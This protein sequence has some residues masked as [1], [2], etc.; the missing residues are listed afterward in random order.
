MVLFSVSEP[1]AGANLHARQLRIGMATLI[2]FGATIGLVLLARNLVI[3]AIM[4]FAAIAFVT[5]LAASIIVGI[6]IYSIGIALWPVVIML[7]GFAWGGKAAIGVSTAFVISIVA[8]TVA[9]LGGT[10]PGPSLSTL[11]GPL[12]FGTVFFLMVILVCWL[13]VSYSRIVFN[14]F[15]T[16][17]RTQRELALSQHQLLAI[18]ETEPE[19]VKVLDTDGTLQQMNRAGLDMIEADSLDQ[20][21]GKSILGVVAP[22]HREAFAALNAQVSQGRPGTLEFEVIGLKGG[23]RWLET[24]AVP[25]RDEDGCVTGLLSVTRDITARRQA[26]ADVM[27]A[28][29]LLEEAIRSLPEGFSIFDQDDRLV[30]CNEAYKNFYHGV[31][32]LIVPGVSFEELARAGAE[33]GQYLEAV[34]RVDQWVTERLAKHRQANG[35][36]LEQHLDDGRWLLIIEYRTPSGYIVGN[37][38]DITARKAAEAELSEYRTRLELL[39]Q[40]RTIA[41]T[42][43]KEAA[44]AAN[45]A[46][47]AFLANMSHEIR[48]PLN[49]ILGMAHILKRSGVTPQQ[50]ERIN[51]I[52]ASAQHLMSIIN[53]ILDIS[54]IEAGRF[55]LEEVQVDIDVLLGNVRSI[56]AERAESKGIRLVIETCPLPPGLIGDQTRLQQALL[57][58]ASNAMKFTDAGSVTL[59]CILLHETADSILV[60]FEVADTGI[61][62]A[63]ETLP[64]LFSAFEQADKSTTRKYGGTGLGLAI[65]RRL[66]ELMGGE[67]GVETAPGSGSTFWFT[68]RLRKGGA[69]P[70]ASAVTFATPEATLRQRYAGSRILV[71]DDEPINREIAHLHLQAAGLVVDQAEDGVQAIDMVQ[72]HSYAAIFMDI[73]MPNLDGLEATRQIRGIPGYSQT[74]IVA[75]TA[76]VFVEDRA[77]CVAAGMNDFLGKPFDPD[78]LFATLLRAL[79]A[80]KL[81]LNVVAA[82]R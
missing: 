41:L 57:N 78:T 69:A 81:I 66:A 70:A 18:I 28:N 27:K 56:I 24:H 80:A 13:T 62:I 34:G 59:R 63:S 73:Q 68:A 11:G 47:S 31:R 21:A 39:V 17:G 53:D 49:G 35:S 37:R 6:G 32:E 65:T 12:F 4:L 79:S 22:E 71:V 54:K 46:K 30:I 60:R 77:R 23:H 61:G 9:Q 51:T 29:R 3:P 19:C 7:V 82:R 67:V 43:A 52:D 36:H 44:E 5:P 50:A 55:V 38:I 16:L 42:V 58:Y 2:P 72:E 40:D 64:R 74:P 76:N 14:A 45:V 8:L 10:L 26:V 33:R 48:T 20:V 75:M 1:P 15:E 25:M